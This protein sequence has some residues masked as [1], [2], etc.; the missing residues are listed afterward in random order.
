[1]SQSL[2]DRPKAEPQPCPVHKVAPRN[3]KQTLREL[4]T[5]D[6]T[7]TNLIMV[8][9]NLAKTYKSG[10]WKE[11]FKFYIENQ[12]GDMASMKPEVKKYVKKMIKDLHVK[13]AEQQNLGELDTTDESEKS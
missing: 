10:P 4:L 1:M 7:R 6:E 9:K 5:E 13:F 12:S 8:L 3:S 11:Y 2:L